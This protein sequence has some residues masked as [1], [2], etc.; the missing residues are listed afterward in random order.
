[1]ASGWRVT[2]ITDG[3]CAAVCFARGAA[4]ADSSDVSSRIPAASP[5]SREHFAVNRFDR[6]DSEMLERLAQDK[7]LKSAAFFLNRSKGAND[8][9]QNELII[10]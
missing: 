9:S 3:A 10:R 1:V 4:T 8:E 6:L 2:S 7:R 5:V